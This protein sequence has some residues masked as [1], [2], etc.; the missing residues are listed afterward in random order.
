VKVIIKV[1]PDNL[2]RLIE[3]LR[4]HG[5]EPYVVSRR[6]YVVAA[7]VPEELIRQIKELDYVEYVTPEQLVKP[8]GDPLVAWI[9]AHL[10]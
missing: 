9:M 5:V 8:L 10:P 2:N 6:F 3:F 1:K 4:R 7:D